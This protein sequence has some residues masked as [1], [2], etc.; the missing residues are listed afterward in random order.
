MTKSA[1]RKAMLKTLKNFA[2]SPEK[3]EAERDIYRELFAT[4]AWQQAKSV[5]LTMS[6]PYEIDTLPLIKQAWAEQKTVA[7]ARVDGPGIMGFYPYEDGNALIA[8]N[9]GIP[10][11]EQTTLLIPELLLVPGV[12]FNGNNQRIGFGGGFYDRYLAGFTGRSIALAFDFQLADNWEADSFD[13]PVEKLII[14]RC[15]VPPGSGRSQ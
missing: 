5:G 2:G 3:R 11:P 12:V 1:L 13:L 15:P 4:D 7:L 9:Y 10:E 6:F 14:G 8:S